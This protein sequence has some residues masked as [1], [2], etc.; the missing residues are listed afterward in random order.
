MKKYLFILVVLFSFSCDKKVE[1]KKEEFV[2][3]EDTIT[4]SYADSVEKALLKTKNIDVEIK[5]KIT[6]VKVL[7]KENKDLK[8]ELQTTKDCLVVAKKEISNMKIKVPKKKSFF[9]KI[10]GTKTDS[11]EIEV[12]D[13]TKIK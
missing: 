9:Q 6:E 2:T 13:T 3:V 8:V 12:I 7:S 11:V 4:V 10:L 5:N 1:N